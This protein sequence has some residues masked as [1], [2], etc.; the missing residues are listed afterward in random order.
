MRQS[1]IAFKSGK[2]TLEGVLSVP[3]ELPQPYPALVA[4]HP[5]PLLGGNMDNPVVT[6]VCR[7]AT[8]MG[9][10]TLRFNYRGVEGSQGEFTNGKREAEDIRNALNLMRQWPGIDRKRLALVGYSFGAALILRELK[11]CKAT[12]SLALIA[13]PASAVAASPIKRDKRPKL[14]IAGQNDRVAPPVALQRALDDVRQPVQFRE[15]PAAD[16]SLHGS[17]AHAAELTADFLAATV[18]ISLNL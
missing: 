14:F 7:A 12:K 6:A 16:H 8:A 5:H 2:L 13:P 9:F 3:D 11:R 4:C 10:A 1:A 18:G 15:I 17:E